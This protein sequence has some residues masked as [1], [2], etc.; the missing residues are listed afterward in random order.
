MVFSA[1]ASNCT[2]A[3][4]GTTVVLH[5]RPQGVYYNDPTGRNRYFEADLD[6]NK[7]PYF[8]TKGLVTAKILCEEMVLD[9]GFV[10]EGRSE[11]EL[12]EMML[13]VQRFNNFAP[14]KWGKDLDEV[15]EA[16]AAMKKEE[17]AEHAALE[18]GGLP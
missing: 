17:E 10:V 5:G 18:S 2:H 9:F 7:F 4:R 16:D 12:P 11:D 13:G 3:R 1:S 6:V 8:A 14:T 15:I